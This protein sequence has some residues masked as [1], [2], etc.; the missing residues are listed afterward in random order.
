MLLLL[1][2][3]HYTIKRQARCPYYITIAT[4]LL[5]RTRNSFCS[6]PL[7]NRE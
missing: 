5:F 3:K 7:A 2:S 1:G 4:D 6:T